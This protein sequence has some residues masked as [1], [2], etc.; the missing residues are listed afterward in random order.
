MLQLR[1]G[2]GFPNAAIGEVLDL[3]QLLSSLLLSLS[4]NVDDTWM[5]I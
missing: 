5:I 4:V 2:P 1:S 3:N